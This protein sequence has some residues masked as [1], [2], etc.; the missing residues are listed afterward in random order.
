[1]INGID[2]TKLTDEELN[3]F[4]RA[5]ESEAKRRSAIR[6]RQALIGLREALGNFLNEGVHYNC[7][8]YIELEVVND[9]GDDDVVEINVF[10]E[11]ILANIKDH[12]DRVVGNYTGE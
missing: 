2:L 4:H 9:R 3:D 6:K 8:R 1:M 5:W 7:D 12:L 10:N 11:E